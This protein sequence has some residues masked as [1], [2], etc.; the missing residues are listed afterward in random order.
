VNGP[1]HHNIVRLAF[2]CLHS[3]K[4]STWKPLGE[5]ALETC[6]LPD[7][8][9][10]ELLRG[11]SGPWRRYFP[12]QLPRI[13]LTAANRRPGPFIPP[14]KFY[15]RYVIRCL[16]NGD[17]DEAARFVG[18]YSHYIGDF[19]QPAHYYELEIGKLLPPPPS[20]KN[21]DYHKMIESVPASIKMLRYRPRILGLSPAELLFRIESSFGALSAQST[22]ALVPMV[23]AIYRR[24]NRNAVKALD[25][26]IAN[27]AK[28]LADFCAS[29]M[30]I[31]RG[32]F[33][34]KTTAHLGKCDLRL[35]EPTCYD[36]EFNFGHKPLIDAV[37]TQSMGRARPFSLYETQG[38]RKIARTTKGI[39]AIPHAL[40]LAGVEPVSSITYRL[41]R[42]TFERFTAKVGLLAGEKP[43]ARVTFEV[44]ADGRTLYK[45]RQMT[46]RDVAEN[47]NLDIRNW[48][49]LVL[50]VTTDGSTDKLAFPIWGEP[51]LTRD[52]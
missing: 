4:A 30:A 6:M 26:V 44:I 19:A 38:R 47:I 51:E 39:C 5:M 12:T 7:D 32:E 46:E 20:L 24:Q 23:T 31:A 1:E 10:L 48:S 8:Y 11:E 41:P 35:I 33:P 16:R 9:A 50:K 3:L 13:N 14:N 22:A 49:K 27:C 34:G 37:T 17:L 52:I 2:Q 40:P 36:V 25:P 42:K 15:I 21:C 28:I 29:C 45:S 18:V 43:Q